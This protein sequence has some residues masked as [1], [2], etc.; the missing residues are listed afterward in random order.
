MEVNSIHQ[1]VLK[2]RDVALGLKKKVSVNSA[3]APASYDCTVDSLLALYDECRSASALAKDK[4]VIKFLS[5]CKQR[6]ILYWGLIN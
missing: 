2:L 1:R 3:L 6:G 4:N 5:K